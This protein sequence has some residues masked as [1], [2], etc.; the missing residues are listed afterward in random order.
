MS[1]VPFNADSA[2]SGTGSTSA[3]LLERLRARDAAAWQRLV[4]LYAP[5]IYQWC[6]HCRLPA[7]DTADI[8]QEVFIAVAGGIQS[9]RRERVGDSFRGWL[10]TITRNKI[11]D[12]HRRH[13]GLPHARGGTEALVHLAQLASDSED[14]DSAAAPGDY[15]GRLPLHSLELV[16]ASVE[17]ATWEAFWLVSAEGRPPA[18]VA[19]QLGV[20]LKSVYDAVYRVRRRLRQELEGLVDETST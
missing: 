4:E 3:S 13:R 20:T 16:R 18:A 10:W 15:R 19:E 14:P 12:H 9:F 1:A 6:R 17:S 7:E 8:T 5:L 11:R 2:L